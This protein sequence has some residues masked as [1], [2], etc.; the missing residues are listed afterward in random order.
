MGD[1]FVDND[2]RDVRSFQPIPAWACWIVLQLS[3]MDIYNRF[4]FYSLLIYTLAYLVLPL[5]V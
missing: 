2:Q 5:D 4:S 1:V 3:F